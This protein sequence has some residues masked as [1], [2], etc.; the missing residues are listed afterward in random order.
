M[1]IFGHFSYIM[2]YYCTKFNLI[3]LDIERKVL[4]DQVQAV[5]M[6]WAAHTDFFKSDTN[7]GIIVFV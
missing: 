4:V 7:G 2:Q 5:E 3:G 1:R 6:Y